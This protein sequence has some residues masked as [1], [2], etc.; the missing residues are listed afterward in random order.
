MK[1]SLCDI[2]EKI[3]SATTGGRIDPL[4]NISELDTGVNKTPN[5]E[6]LPRKYE[7]HHE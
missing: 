7:T 3:M 1:K 5:Q 4:S 6:N 2:F